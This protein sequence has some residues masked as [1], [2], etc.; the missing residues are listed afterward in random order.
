MSLEN[1]VFGEFEWSRT[2]ENYIR[3]I[4]IARKVD[5]TRLGT[6]LDS[7]LTT[8]LTELLKDF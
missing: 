2:F 8:L 5:T 1:T 4:Y 3:G 7:R 6:A